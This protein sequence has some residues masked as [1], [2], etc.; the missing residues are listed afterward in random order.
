M[1]PRKPLIDLLAALFGIG[2][3]VSINGLWVELPLLVTSLPEGW[4]LPSY[5][6]V[7]IQIANVGPLLFTLA[8]SLRPSMRSEPVVYIVLV[9]GCLSS[10]MLTVFWPHTTFLAG[11]EHSTALLVLVFLLSL[12]DCTSSV[13]F[14]PYMAMWR[15]V[16]LPSYLVGEGLSGLLPGLVAL[17][18]G[19]GGN[20]DCVNVTRWNVTE[21]G[22]VSYVVRV[23]EE[24]KPLF[25][26]TDFFL[27]LFAMMVT[28]LLA[29]TSLEKLPFIQSERSSAALLEEADPSPSP[30]AGNVTFTHG[31][32]ASEMGAAS[33]GSSLNVKAPMK[34]MVYRL[35]L[36]GLA[37]ACLLANGLLPSIQS[38]SCG[39]Y[40]NVAY[41]LAATLSALANPTAAFLTLLLPRARPKV[42]TGL[43]LLASL[44]ASYILATALLSP[45]PPLAG[46]SLGEAL[47]VLAWVIFTGAMTYVRVEIANLMR[48]EGVTALF[49][50]GAVT[51]AGS[52]VGAVTAFILVNVLHLFTPYYPCS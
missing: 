45:V 42:L 14:L 6:S 39:A 15:G 21:N 44:T 36:V 37:W 40:G 34:P 9:L 24:L 47:I 33:H 3:W 20:P 25:S 10:F 4:S 16:Y 52:A 31:Q 13:L 27:F 26:V 17:V 46:S 51:Q 2:A 38:F 5:L 8:R 12:V 22:N 29:F 50:S 48:G 11:A 32:R 1:A 18:Q 23:P 7:I 28:S 19:V 30:S 35:L 41:H 49:W 43:A